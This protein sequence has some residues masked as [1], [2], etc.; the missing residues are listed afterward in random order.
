MLS[1][2]TGAHGLTEHEAARLL[3]EREPYIATT[4]R[5]YTSIV[6]ANVFTVFNLILAVA[7]AATLAFGAVMWLAAAR[8]WFTAGTRRNRA[9]GRTGLVT[10]CYLRFAPLSGEGSAEGLRRGGR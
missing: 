8:P 9:P 1:G 6:R 2:D 10:T 7:G 3:A 4:S 5:S